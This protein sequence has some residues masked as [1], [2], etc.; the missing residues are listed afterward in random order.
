MNPPRNEDLP[1][2]VLWMEFLKWLLPTTE[3]FPR[4]VRFTFANRIDTLALD[5]VED[6]VE[7]R[8]SRDKREI[9]KRTNLRLEKIRVLLRICHEERFLSHDAF[10]FA[11]K[12]VDETGRMLGGWMKQQE[13]K[14]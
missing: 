9:L 5:V 3:K 1:V 13:E 7:A 10:E 14:R 4:R 6:L 2:F 11:I 8:Y 12:G